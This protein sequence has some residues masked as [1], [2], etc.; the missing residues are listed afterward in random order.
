VKNDVDDTK[1]GANKGACYAEG[2]ALRRALTKHMKKFCKCPWPRKVQM[3]MAAQ[4]SFGR[5]LFGLSSSHSIDLRK[6][7][8]CKFG[9]GCQLAKESLADD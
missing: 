4:R 9:V 2:R 1:D 7:R 3:S 8:R 5:I 6:S